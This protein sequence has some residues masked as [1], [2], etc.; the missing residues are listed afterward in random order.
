MRKF[1]VWAPRAKDVQLKLSDKTIPL[2]AGERG[3]WTT[4][5]NGA[6]AGD[7]YSYI[8]DGHDP[9]IPDPRSEFQPFGVDGASR[10]V[11]HSYFPWTDSRWQASPLAAAIVYELHIGTFT[12]GGTFESAIE[13]LDYLAE[14]GITQC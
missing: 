8:L 12:E 6:K 2:Q 3:Y 11:D 13:R 1:E 9:P 5:V 14:L 10:L 7:D 4:E